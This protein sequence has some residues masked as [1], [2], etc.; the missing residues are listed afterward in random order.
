MR[1]C[2]TRT[3]APHSFQ[4]FLDI[5]VECVLAV[6]TGENDLLCDSYITQSD[7]R[8]LAGDR[9][10]VTGSIAD[11]HDTGAVGRSTQWS[12]LE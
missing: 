3:Q 4:T 8:T 5:A 12:S 1:V 6:I 9:I 10:I 7:G 2:E 11:Q